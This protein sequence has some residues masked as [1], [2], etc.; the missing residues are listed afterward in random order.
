VNG[1]RIVRANGVDLCVETFG[2]QGDPAILLMAGLAQSMDAWDPEFCVRLAA[3]L[4]YVIRY[5]NRDTGRSTSYPA[6]KPPYTGADLTADALGL[7]DALEVRQAHLVGVSAGGGMA[8]EIALDHPDRVASLTLIDTSSIDPHGPG[9]PELPPPSDE[10]RA[11]FAQPPAPPDWADRDAVI[12]YMVAGERPFDGPGFDEEY[13]RKIADRTV[14]RTKNVEASLTNHWIMDQGDDP[15]RPRI[16]QITVPTL[17][18]H[19]TADPL[20]P[21]A[22]GEALARAIPGARL[23]PL[24]GVG[25]QIPPPKVWDVV[26]P[27]L[28]HHTSG[29]WEEQGERLVARSRAAGDPTGWFDRLYGA[30]AAGEVPMPWSRTEPNPL[31]AEWARARGLTGAGQKAIVVGCGLGADAEFV[32]GLGYDTVAFDIAPTAVRVAKER[33]P[34]TSVEY[35]VADLLDPPV[36]WTRAFDLVVEIITV[37]ALPDPPRRTAIVNVGRL[38][39]PGGTLIAVAYS[40]E[41]ADPDGSPPP[42]P[43]TRDEIEAFATDGLDPVRIENAPFPGRPDDIRWRAE[44]RRSP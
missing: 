40:A 32:A 43:L 41:H 31:L 16:G 34:G 19:G 9:E 24:E 38:V 42:W 27:A 13:V 21:Y 12:D 3:G 44:F 33:H 5:D 39:A 7:L 29:G 14:D 25:H 26:V 15:D 37:Q 8:Q 6:G 22:H 17:V 1:E 18:M 2:D 20:F 4:R 30:A 28:L 35:V 10:M 11:F 23:I 36:R